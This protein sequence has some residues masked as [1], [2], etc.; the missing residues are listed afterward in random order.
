[1]STA[2]EAWRALD[3]RQRDA[4]RILVDIHLIDLVNHWDSDMREP[5]VDEARAA[6]VSAG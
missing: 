1:M 2:Q 4:L 6:S 3:S 5:D